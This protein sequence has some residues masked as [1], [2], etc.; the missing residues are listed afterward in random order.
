M[1]KSHIRAAIRVIPDFPKPGASAT[2]LHHPATP[3]LARRVA[4]TRGA[5]RFAAAGIMFQDI[6]TLL[7]NP[8]AYKD[9]CSLLEERYRGFGLDAIAGF[10][11][12]GF[13]FGPPLAL[14]LG[15]PFVPLRKPKKLPGASLPRSGGTPH[16]PP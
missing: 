15:L 12:R 4:L 9:C 2:R 6:T 3:F 13:F 16:A 10:E 8:V 11:A 14:A 1:R 7:L 5:L